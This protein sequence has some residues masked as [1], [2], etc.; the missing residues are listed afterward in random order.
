M[1]PHKTQT[2]GTKKDYERGSADRGRTR[3]RKPPSVGGT[4]RGE[5]GVKL[6]Q[7]TKNRDSKKGGK[8]PYKKGGLRRGGTRNEK[9]S[10][11]GSKHEKEGRTLRV[12]RDRYNPKKGGM[13]RC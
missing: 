6:K 10:A 1:C 5:G 9:V 8:S 3:K 12:K 4:D 2:S 11:V 7:A 13:A